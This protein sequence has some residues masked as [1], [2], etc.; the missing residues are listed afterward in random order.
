MSE[1]AT[2]C[3]KCGKA[4]HCYVNT[5]KRVYHCFKCG[6]SG[7]SSGSIT[8][9]DLLLPAKA[10]AEGLEEPPETYHN[11]TMTRVDEEYVTN[12][13]EAPQEIWEGLLPPIV[14]TVRGLL[15]MFPSVPY[16]QER[17]WDAFA[18]P[19]WVN[20][21]QAPKSKKTVPGSEN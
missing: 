1:I 17:R 14:S 12:R 11:R 19:R 3:P 18:P 21:K 5:V 8:G 2:D 4:K 6:A 13:L 10:V 16:W 15:F 7:R 20:P 9:R